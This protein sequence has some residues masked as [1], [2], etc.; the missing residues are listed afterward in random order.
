M[1]RLRRLCSHLVPDAVPCGAV[2][3]SAAVLGALGGAAVT[4]FAHRRVQ[5]TQQQQQQQSAEAEAEAESTQMRQPRPHAV[6]TEAELR[7]LLPPRPA[8]VGDKVHGTGVNDAIKVRVRQSLSRSCSSAV[9]TRTFQCQSMCAN[10][11]QLGSWGGVVCV[12]SDGRYRCGCG[13][14]VDAGD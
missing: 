1:S 2:T 4:H 6:T 7:A 5:Q 3:V 13:L 8:G 9:P 10:L 14:A 11:C 12:Q